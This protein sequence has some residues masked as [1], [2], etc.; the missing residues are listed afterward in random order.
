MTAYSNLYGGIEAGGTKF[1][2]AVGSADGGLAAEVRFETTSPEETIGKSIAFFRQLPEPITAVGIGSFGPLDLDPSSTSYGFITN[3]DKPGWRDTDF[4]GTVQRSLGVPVGFDTDVNA[5]ALGEHRWGAGVGLDNFLYLTVG[6]GIGGGGVF[7]G[8][9]MHGLIHPEMGHIRI[10]HD[11]AVDPFP[12]TCPYHGDCLE[13]LAGGRTMETRYGQPAET[14][15][16][17]HPAWA[18]EARYLALGIANFIVTL[19]P[20]RIIVGGGVM[21]KSGL[22]EAVRQEVVELLAGYVNAPAV[23]ENIENYIVPP[24]LGNH[25]GVLG[26][27]SLAEQAAG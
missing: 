8:R 9:P 15:P 17:D 27:I 19:S 12:G 14:L 25:A 13:G 2:C 23:T 4:A 26:A 20:Q 18:L 16:D 7:G 10:P 6:T 22:L 1:I 5:A 21:S 24:V 11:F 3:S